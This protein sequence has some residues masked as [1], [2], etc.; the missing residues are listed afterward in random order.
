MGNLAGG[1]VFGG[2]YQRSDIRKRE[3]EKRKTYPEITESAEFTEQR[4]EAKP[5][6]QVKN[7][8]WGA[9]GLRVKR[10]ALV[11]LGRKSPPIHTKGGAPSSSL[12]WPR[13]RESPRAQSGMTG[14]QGRISQDPGTDSVPGATS[15]RRRKN[16][17]V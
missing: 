11:A 12:G 10:R 1:G 4:G 7:R 16:E 5:K 9:P 14:P 8:T 17:E 13:C 15:V 2:G 6:T 3:F